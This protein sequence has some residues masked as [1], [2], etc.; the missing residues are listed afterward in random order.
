MK[1][2]KMKNKKQLLRFLKNKVVFLSACKNNENDFKNT[3]E[4]NKELIEKG[5]DY[6]TLLGNYG[7]Y[8]ISFAVKFKNRKELDYLK[9]LAKKYSQESILVVI[10]KKA[11]IILIDTNKVDLEFNKLR[12]LNKLPEQYFSVYENIIFKFE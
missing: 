6:I 10:N 4:L 12:I 9:D 5:F 8:E 7:Y 2:L 1:G 3:I 11:K